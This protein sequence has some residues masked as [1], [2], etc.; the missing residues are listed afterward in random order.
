[1]EWW[2]WATLGLATLGA[3]LGIRAE[4]ARSSDRKVAINKAFAETQLL[5][6][7]FLKLVVETPVRL[8]TDLTGSAQA[9]AL[10]HLAPAEDALQKIM[11]QIV[12][13]MPHL[14]DNADKVLQGLDLLRSAKPD[15]NEVEVC[16]AFERIYGG[17]KMLTLFEEYRGAMLQTSKIPNLYGNTTFQQLSSQ[18]R[19]FAHRR[20]ALQHRAQ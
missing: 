5:L 19:A 10:D 6:R 7:P 13:A 3:I 11:P 18:E 1:M 17:A 12:V 14:L 15:S 8:P 9:A 20:I 2:N 4:R 16:E